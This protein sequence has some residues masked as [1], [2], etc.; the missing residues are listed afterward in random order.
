[1]LRKFSRI[2]NTF[3]Q[4]GAQITATVTGRQRY[5]SDLGLE[6]PYDL[7]F[8]GHEQHIEKLKRVIKLK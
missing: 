5:L 3:L 8:A 6:M 2:C 4:L 7:T 1:M